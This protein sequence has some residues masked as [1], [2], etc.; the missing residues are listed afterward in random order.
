M[1]TDSVE[2]PLAVFYMLSTPREFREEAL[3]PELVRSAGESGGDV[4]TGYSYAV[5]DSLRLR[6]HRNEYPFPVSLEAQDIPS[7]EFE[8]RKERDYDV[9]WFRAASD[10]VVLVARKRNIV[11]E[12]ITLFAYIFCAS[13]LLVGIF[14]LASFSL[15]LGQERGGRSD[16]IGI[17][18][19]Q[20]IQGTV[21]FISIFT[22]L[23][24]GAVTI[25]L[26]INRYER[27]NREKLGRTLQ[28]LSDELHER[29]RSAGLP[30]EG[31]W[32]KDSTHDETMLRVISDLSEI[33]EADVNLYN[34]EGD[35]KISSQPFVYN[36]GILSRKMDP[37]AY[38]QMKRRRRV[39]FVQKERYG[40]LEYISIYTP[41]RNRQGEL[42][43]YVNIPY[44]A[45]TRGLKQEISSFLVAL[46]NLNTF[47]FL[48]GGIISVLLTQ[49]LTRSFT[50][51]GRKMME[52]SLGRHNE[53]IVWHRKDEI[54]V[55]VAQYNR[56]VR[57]LEESAAALAR[58]ER[59]GA[60]REMARQVAHEIKN[61]LTPMKL[62]IQYL[63]KAI[64]QDAPQVPQLAAR[65]SA[66]LIEQ[67]EHLSNIAGDFAE[68]ANIGTSDAGDLDLRGVIRSVVS[69]HA[70]SG[71]ADIGCDLPERPI[72]LHA[73]KTQMNRLFTNLL[74]NAME[75]VPRE[76]RAVIRTTARLHDAFV[77]VSV[78][79]NGTGIP[80]ETWS[81]IFRPNFTT[82]SS[83][84][85]LGL[86]MSWSIVEKAGGRIWFD[87]EAGAGTVFHVRL[88][89]AGHSA[90]PGPGEVPVEAGG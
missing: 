50:W 72:P 54:G 90:V 79:D 15:R 44:F 38:W 30:P 68:F 29:L 85:G 82:K 89:L 74:R 53:E 1:V 69:L 9:L 35:L 28:V 19:G 37:V 52:I 23:V 75:A 73:D 78:Q 18:I 20:Q 70:M 16:R 34:E 25:V 40:Q 64:V 48:I 56:M 17:G 11:L 66:T 36:E 14:Q 2:R 46:I 58:T 55:L 61:P 33:H 3:Y 24:I 57:K 84:T 60:W 31:R 10:K 13:L 21:I 42:R 49:R 32:L 47:V 4:L 8:F 39:Q 63:Q 51:I 87:T 88:P 41:F 45:S 22:F 83:G 6:M 77:D 81:N 76:R 80:T 67:I 62:S 12:G 65:V 86:A 27:N 43:A 7:E 59:E 71:D 5:Y 26:F